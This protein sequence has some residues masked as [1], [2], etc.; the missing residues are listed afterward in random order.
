[1]HNDIPVIIQK[2]KD[3]TLL[4]QEEAEILVGEIRRLIGAFHDA[5]SEAIRLQ[6]EIW[7]S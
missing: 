4:S 7:R 2:V 1:M 3:K 5:Q 6:R